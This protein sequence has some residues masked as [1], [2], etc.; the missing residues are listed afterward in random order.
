MNFSKLRLG[1]VPM[2]STD[3]VEVNS[4]YILETLRSLESFRLDLVCFPENSLY[5]NFN[6]KIDIN[7]ALTLREPVWK[8]L[9]TW[10]Q[11]QQCYIHMGGVPLNEN[12]KVFNASVLMDPE[13]QK[14]IVY[15]KI[16]LFYVN[17]QGRVVSESD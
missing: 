7:S 14:K 17:V 15:R 2:T 5:F 9:A 11:Q 16:H 10:A 3:Q 8:D 13:G 12:N 6:S 1:L 4:K